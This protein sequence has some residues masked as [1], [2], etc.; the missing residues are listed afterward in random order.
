MSSLHTTDGER[1][2]AFYGAVFGWPSAHGSGTQTV[3]WGPTTRVSM[4]GPPT[5]SARA[6][7][8]HV[9]SFATRVLRDRSIEPPIEILNRDSHRK[10][11]RPRVHPADPDATARPRISAAG[12][13][14]TG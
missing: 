4:T 10:P 3:N 14:Q 6:R 5:A 8:T 12:L 1:A 11:D 2:K 7:S 9:A 13:N